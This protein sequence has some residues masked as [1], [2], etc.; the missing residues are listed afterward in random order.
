MFTLGEM[1]CMGACVNAPMIAVADYTKVGAGGRLR[2]P[3]SDTAPCRG[4]CWHHPAQ[5]CCTGLDG[6]AA[7]GQACWFV[8]QRM[9]ENRQRRKRE[10]A[11]QPSCS[12][13]VAAWGCLPA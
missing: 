9:V 10:E 4:M 3:G 1:E 7:S 5:G 6:C 2:Q 13:A 11:A 12:P 8:L